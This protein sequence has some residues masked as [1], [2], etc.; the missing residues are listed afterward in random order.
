MLGY[1][2]GNVL[3]TGHVTLDDSL[4]L[5]KHVLIEPNAGSEL[6]GAVE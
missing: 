1:A 6:V 5:N 3:P 4:C 2:R